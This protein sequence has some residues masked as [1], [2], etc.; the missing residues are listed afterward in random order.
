L[1]KVSFRTSQA[2]LLL[3]VAVF[4]FEPGLARSETIESA[5][6]RAYAGNP[7]LN[8]SRAGVRATDENVPNRL[9]GYRPRIT[10][11]GDIGVSSTDSRL[12]NNNF[13]NSNTVPRGGGLQ[14][15]QT[16][17]NGGRTG[18]SVRQA[19]AGVLQAREQLRQSEQGI[20][21]SGATA[22][23]DVLR[24]TAILNLR[25]NNIDVLD[26][27]LR[28]T[29][30]RF[31]VG[32]VTRTD[33]AQAEARLASAR[34]DA[35][36]AAGNLKSSMA[37][38]RQVIGVEARQLSPAKALDAV[39]PRT[40]DSAV[41][42]SQM[43][44][45]RVLAALHAVDAA[46]LQIKITES[47]LLPSAGLTGTLTHRWDANG[48]NVEQNSATIGGTLSVPI[49]EG[50]EVYSRVRQAKET[51][52]QRRI[53][54]DQERD[55]VRQNVVSSWGQLEATKERITASQAQ[56]QAAE[57]ALNGVREE[58]KVG[59]RTTLD[60][61]N[62]Q[63]ELLTARVN[64]I[65]AQRDRVV[66]SYALLSSTGR[67]SAVNLRLAVEEYQPRVHYDQVRDK[68]IGLRTPDG[69]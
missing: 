60:V 47:E 61:L 64:L 4:A 57:I 63:Q 32:E 33:V 65:T 54:A 26:E 37:T 2:A 52:S 3:G 49:Y 25:N 42:L 17:F 14:I 21:L 16:L 18:N 15:T 5:L 8:S 51:L 59:Q 39:L 46:E 40:L 24:D 44:H 29:R 22:Y 48:A 43:E 30:D 1:L 69:K 67:L 66:A 62:A 58:A 35:S 20:L 68:W 6:A 13:N 11:S 28:Q 27:Q 38:Y 34:S 12:G 10:A 7:T 56:I 36:A 50:G 19:D 9:A 41:A 53:D 23:M 55:A 31:S 45:P